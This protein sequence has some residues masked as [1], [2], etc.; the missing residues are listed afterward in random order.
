MGDGKSLKRWTGQQ[1]NANRPS[2]VRGYARSR[3]DGPVLTPETVAAALALWEST[4]DM[5]A[6]LATVSPRKRYWVEVA[7]RHYIGEER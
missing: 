5:A 6:V 3:T 4:H 2:V 1:G 7:I